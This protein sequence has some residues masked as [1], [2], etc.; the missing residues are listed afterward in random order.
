MNKIKTEGDYLILGD[1]RQQSIHSSITLVEAMETRRTCRAYSK[2]LVDKKVLSKILKLSMNAASAC[3]EQLWYFVD[4]D[5]KDLLE[6]LYLRGSAAFLTKTNQAILVLYDNSTINK[7]YADHIQSGS[8][9]ISNF[10]LA[11]HSFGVGTCWVCHLPRKAE[12]KRLF[13][14]PKNLDPVALITYGYYKGKIRK[15]KTKF[16]VEDC[17][18]INKFSPL[19]NH[20]ISSNL[21]KRIMMEVYY[22]IPPILRKA[23]R[24]KSFPFEKKFYNYKD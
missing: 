21:F 20:K 9:F 13:N 4:V 18:S 7:K 14:I 23:L 17:L 8:S 19:S 11:A 6:E 3:N 15:R 16:I 2:V 10:M 24:R 5:D 22:L 1:V 12:L